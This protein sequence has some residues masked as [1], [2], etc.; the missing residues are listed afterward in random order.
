MA[1]DFGVDMDKEIFVPIKTADA[2]QYLDDILHKNICN[3]I[4]GNINKEL[5]ID[6]IKKDKIIFSDEIL[7]SMNLLVEELTQVKKQVQ[8][9]DVLDNQPMT[10]SNMIDIITQIWCKVLGFNRININESFFDLG[11][12]S[13]NAIY[14]GKEINIRFPEIIE[15]SDIFTYNTVSK[16]AVFIF[17]VMISQ[18]GQSNIQKEQNNVRVSDNSLDVLLDK[19][20]SGEIG[21]EDLDLLLEDDY[22]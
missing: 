20:A 18:I 14:I 16:L 12:N 8:K 5:I 1:V 13:I 9:L 10:L 6:K 15:L 2:I 7:L 21:E 11:G 22:V 4:V 17:N 3:L 19:I